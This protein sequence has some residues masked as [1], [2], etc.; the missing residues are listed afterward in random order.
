M[1]VGGRIA[2]QFPSILS[3]LDHGLQMG[4]ISRM[5]NRWVVAREMD[6]TDQRV[7]WI[8]GASMFIR[9]EVFRA[10]GG[11]DEQY[12]LYYEETDFCRRANEAGFF[13]MVCA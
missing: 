3:E 10:I 11:L 8:C 6:D 9:G 1:E 4:P 2:F 13:Y 12:F 7:D 5:L